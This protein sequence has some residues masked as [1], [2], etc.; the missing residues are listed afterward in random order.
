MQQIKISLNAYYK[1][2]FDRKTRQRNMHN[3]M[4]SKTEFFKYVKIAL[5]GL[6]VAMSGTGGA[7]FHITG[8]QH[9]GVLIALIGI[10]TV[11]WG[12]TK[13]MLILFKSKK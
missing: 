8:L 4:K 9:I 2:V 3:K 7:I 10:A 12:A 11:W 13:A 6:V 5:L 1:D